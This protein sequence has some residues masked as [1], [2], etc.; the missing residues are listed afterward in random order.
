MDEKV[1]LI[2]D[3]ERLAKDL[4]HAL[5]CCMQAMKRTGPEAVSAWEN[6]REMLVRAAE[7]LS[8]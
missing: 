8:D 5:W 3:Y 4:R 1:Q 6:G 2:A 7:M